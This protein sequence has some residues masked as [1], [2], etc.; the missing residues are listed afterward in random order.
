MK[1]EDER[2]RRVAALFGL[3]S[4]VYVLVISAARTKILWYVMP[5]TPLLSVVCA[6]GCSALL[7]KLCRRRHWPLH[8]LQFAS[9]LVCLALVARTNIAHANYLVVDSARKEAD[10]YSF[11]LRSGLLERHAR[12][13]ESVVIVHP[14]FPAW[15]YLG[16]YV[17]PTLYYVR[18]LREKGYEAV[19]QPPTT[20]LPN[21]PHHVVA[22]GGTAHLMESKHPALRLIEASGPCGLYRWPGS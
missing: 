11:V 12:S 17:A 21:G 7:E 6:I 1:G 16:H 14:G 18:L 9:A 4:L 10:Q 19:I 15:A 2:T 8:G 22:C 20:A 3:C 13:D 5:V